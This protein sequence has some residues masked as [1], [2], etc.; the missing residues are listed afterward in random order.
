MYA[1]TIIFRYSTDK[2]GVDYGHIY[3]SLSA[4]PGADQVVSRYNQREE[5]ESVNKIVKSTLHAKR[6]RTRA[7]Q[8][9]EA[10]LKI[11][12][13]LNCPMFSAVSF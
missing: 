13:L 12:L 1:R 7:E 3:T 9:I 5:I 11:N 2:D 4:S 6:L 8:S 10:F